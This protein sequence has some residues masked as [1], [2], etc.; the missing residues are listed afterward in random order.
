M[1]QWGYNP[2][3]CFFLITGYGAHLDGTCFH[4]EQKSLINFVASSRRFCRGKYR[5]IPPAWYEKSRDH[6]H[7]PKKTDWSRR[8]CTWLKTIQQQQQNRICVIH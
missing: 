2:T 6:Y 3:Y 4:F 5:I 1:G 8:H 7:P